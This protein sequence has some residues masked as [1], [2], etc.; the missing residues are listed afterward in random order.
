MF[1]AQEVCSGAKWRTDDVLLYGVGI[2]EGEIPGPGTVPLL[3]LDISTSC[4]LGVVDLA[5]DGGMGEQ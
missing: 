2:Q 1:M 4:L 5:Q 3:T